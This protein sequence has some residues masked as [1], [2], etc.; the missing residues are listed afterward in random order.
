MGKV[1]FPGLTSF[2]LSYVGFITVLHLTGV[3]H[4]PFV[5]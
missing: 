5:A 2:G 4:I 3:R 1:Q